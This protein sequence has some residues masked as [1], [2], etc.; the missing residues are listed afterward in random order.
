MY[1]MGQF[2]MDSIPEENKEDFDFFRFPIIDPECAD[3]RRRADRRLL[4]R[5]ERAAS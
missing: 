4:R 5:C 3:R 1:L 2:V